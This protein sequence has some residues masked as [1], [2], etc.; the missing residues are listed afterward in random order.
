MEE[1]MD[2]SSNIIQSSNPEA[3]TAQMS[4][5]QRLTN[6]F[7][8]PSKA[9]QDINR[10]PTWLGMLILTIIIAIGM[11][12]LINT[13]VDLGQLVLS[14]GAAQMPEE[15]MRFLSKII[16]YGI[17]IIIPISAVV[18][19]LLFSVIF[20][21]I[22]ILVGAPIKFKK[23]FAVNVWAMGPPSIVS[24]I[25]SSIV[26]FIKD[27]ETIQ[28][29]NLLT[30]N[31]GVLVS[32]RERPVLATFLSSIDLFT[33]WIIALMAIGYAAVSDRMLSTKKAATTIIVLWAVY[34]LVKVGIKAITN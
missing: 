10:K 34:V 32:A 20:L 5:M 9:F 28:L 8:E 24:S 23:L 12:V 25:L 26:A 19:Y 17:Y 4:F 31:L 16:T 14:S 13:R 2:E 1:A 21:G 3:E 33:I 7:F 15:Q 22:F 18:S 11:F 29:N 6:I 30:T 27:P